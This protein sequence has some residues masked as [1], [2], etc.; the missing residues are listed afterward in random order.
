MVD[1][2]DP[3]RGDRPAGALDEGGDV[4]DRDVEQVPPRSGDLAVAEAE[5]GGARGRPAASLPA[6]WAWE[7]S[8]VRSVGSTVSA[9]TT[10]SSAQ[11][12]ASRDRRAR[13]SSWPPA[14]PRL[15][16]MSRTVAHRRSAG[17][18]VRS[19]S[20]ASRT[21]RARHTSTAPGDTSTAVTS[22]PRSWN[23]RLWRPA[24][25]PRSS[26]GPA[27]ASARTARSS[28]DHASAVRKNVAR[29]HRGGLVAVVHRQDQVGPRPPGQ[30]VGQGGAEGV[31][32][33]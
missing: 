4:G 18:S 8:S 14:R 7:W 29:R 17:G 1:G 16:H 32:V 33:G 19:A 11:T 10:A 6:W 2:R 12:A 15:P 21:P 3:V 31:L 13:V 20:R 30:M 9:T 22:C 27:A 26:T 5:A 23:H 28:G 25:A 24:P